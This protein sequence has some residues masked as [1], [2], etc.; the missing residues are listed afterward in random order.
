[1]DCEKQKSNRSLSKTEMMIN[2]CLECWE[3]AGKGTMLVTISG[4]ADSTAL[5]LAFHLAKIP[6]VAVHCNFNL[7]GEE[8]TRD[9]EFVAD[10]C[11]KKSIPLAIIEFDTKNESLPGESLEMTCRRLRY[12]AFE[13]LAKKEEASRIVLAHNAD[14]NVETFLLNALRGSGVFG[15]KA[16]K[17][18]TGKL[19]RPLLTLHR[20]DILEFL[21]ENNQPFVTDSSNLESGFRRNFLRNEVIPLLET[22]WPGARKSLVKTIN[23]LE[24]EADIVSNS[25]ESV[26]KKDARCLNWDIIQSYPEPE[27]LIFRFINRYGGSKSIAEEILRSVPKHKS[28]KHWKLQEGITAVFTRRGIE[29]K[30]PADKD[31]SE[32]GSQVYTW[33][34]IS[35]EQLTKLNLQA[36]GNSAVYLPFSPEHYEFRKADRAMKIK[37]LGLRGSQNVFKVLKDAGLSPDERENTEVLVE[38]TTDAVIWIPGIKRSSLHLLEGNEE[39]IFRLGPC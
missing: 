21:K 19:L 14:D 29:I 16:M 24:R 33:K 13:E 4:G 32:N 2:K 35:G 18:D 28:G 5:L 37:S 22:R 7:R 10:F 25:L 20:T 30:P 23:I 3:K 34:K 12:A 9:M 36:E 6:C 39:E 11:E 1:M 31:V 15:L 27:T 8:S 38:K 26:L 17:A